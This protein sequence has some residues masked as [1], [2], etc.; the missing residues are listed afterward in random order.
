M[1]H[2]KVFK[3]IHQLENPFKSPHTTHMSYYYEK[4]FPLHSATQKKI[5]RK[6]DVK[7]YIFIAIESF[8]YKLTHNNMYSIKVSKGLNMKQA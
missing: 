1:L 6:R 8:C 2:E 7:I 5:S 4:Y 3:K